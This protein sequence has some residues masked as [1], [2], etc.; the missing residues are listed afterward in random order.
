MDARS[1]LAAAA[2]PRRSPRVGKSSACS[3]AASR[4][5]G[6][7]G[8]CASRLSLRSSTCAACKDPHNVTCCAKASCSDFAD[9]WRAASPLIADARSSPR[10]ASKARRA[11]AWPPAAASIGLRFSHRLAPNI[12]R[13]ITALR[14]EGFGI[15][16][17]ASTLSRSALWAAVATSFPCLPAHGGACSG[18][19]ISSSGRQPTA[20]TGM[21]CSL[22]SCILTSPPS[23]CKHIDGACPSRTACALTTSSSAKSTLLA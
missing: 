19:D 15:G 23:P 11:A 16:V 10:S 5:C 1:C 2:T 18:V 7:S 17:K 13:L 21:M 4:T 6:S 12:Q 3:P 14:L 9:A 20:A 22:M 8:R